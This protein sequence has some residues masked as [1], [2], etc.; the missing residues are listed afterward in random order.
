MKLHWMNAPGQRWRL[1]ETPIALVDWFDAQMQK[2]PVQ[3]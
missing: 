2:R 1:T 3:L